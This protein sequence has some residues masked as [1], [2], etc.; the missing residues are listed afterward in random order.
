MIPISKS[1]L[2][3][4]ELY[5]AQE[6]LLGLLWLRQFWTRPAA[7]TESLTHSP[8]C[9]LPRQSGWAGS[10]GGTPRFHGATERN[11]PFSVI[12]MRKW[13]NTAV[14]WLVSLT[15]SCMRKAFSW[16]LE[17]QSLTDAE[18]TAWHCASVA[19]QFTELQGRLLLKPMMLWHRVLC[20]LLCRFLRTLGRWADRPSSSSAPRNTGCQATW[21]RSPCWCWGPLGPRHRRRASF[22]SPETPLTK[23]LTS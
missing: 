11:L 22:P 21:S 7:L 20:C 6:R 12:L 18:D 4:T 3:L 17:T 13:R 16:V 23:P 14:N 15:P 5:H 2:F 10:S 19:G 1:F 9:P 8:Q